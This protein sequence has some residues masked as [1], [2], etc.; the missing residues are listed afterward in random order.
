MKYSQWIG[1]A[2]ALLLIGVC[3]LPWAYYPELQKEFT[4]FFSEN[5][6]YGRPGKIFMFFCG[7]A[8]ILY[9]IP[10]IWAKRANLF[11]CAINFA[12]AINIFIRF[13]GCARGVCPEKRIGIFLMLLASIIMVVAAVLPDIQLKDKSR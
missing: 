2:A 5:N 3:Y 6:V 10:R 9:L 8:I 12:F 7:I 11:V 1:V 4:G 13:T